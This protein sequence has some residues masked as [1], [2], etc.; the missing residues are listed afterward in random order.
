MEKK[1]RCIIFARCST[2]KQFTAGQLEPA[3]QF[4]RANGFNDDQ[5][6][7]IEYNESG[8][9]LSE[10]ERLGLNE[11]KKYIEDEENNVKCVFATEISRIAR[12]VGVLDSIFKYLEKHQIQLK[13]RTPEMTLLDSNGKQSPTS[14]IIFSLFGCIAEN[15]INEKLERTAYGKERCHAQGFW[16]GAMLPL[17]YSVSD[18]AE[19]NKK[20]I[21]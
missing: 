10:E 11:M 4:A 9:R 19:K 21:H 1:E 6:I 3:K 5:F 18:K 7:I 17:G 8:Y 13:I 14:R 15:E 2:S 16:D 12:T 20:S